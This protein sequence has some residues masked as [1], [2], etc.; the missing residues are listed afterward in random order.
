MKKVLTS[1]FFGLF[2]T[3]ILTSVNCSNQQSNEFLLT[4]KDYSKKIESLPN[5]PIIDV[6][7]PEEFKT[8][9]IAKAV[10]FNWNG[11]KFLSQIAKLDKTKPVFVYCHAGGRSNAAASKMRSIGFKK[12]YD[13]SG[14]LTNW[15]AASLPVKM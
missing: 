3:S 2:I 4:A 5:A 15:K 9:H 12:V 6:R 11:D 8:G 13:L 1:L 7:T 14:G 10:N